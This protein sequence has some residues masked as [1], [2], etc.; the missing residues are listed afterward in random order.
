MAECGDGDSSKWEAV[1]G[2]MRDCGPGS[3]MAECGDGDS[4]NGRPYRDP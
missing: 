3:S 2:P 4:S 1:Q